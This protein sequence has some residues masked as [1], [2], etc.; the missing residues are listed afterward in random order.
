M[1]HLHFIETILHAFYANM[2]IIAIIIIYVVV[3]FSHYLFVLFW[4]FVVD[5]SMIFSLR[6]PLG[7]FSI[8]FFP[9]LQFIVP[10]HI[11]FCFSIFLL[12]GIIEVSDDTSRVEAPSS[13]ENSK[14]S[15]F[16]ILNICLFLKLAESAIIVQTLHDFLI[17][18]KI[19]RIY[20]Q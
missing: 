15:Q 19:K 13:G 5:V 10:R 18:I 20:T 3:L 12:I 14:L 6:L 11:I 7:Q 1:Q 9:T 8:F 4:F 2:N 17:P 16:L